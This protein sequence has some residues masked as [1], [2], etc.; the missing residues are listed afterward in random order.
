MLLLK[1]LTLSKTSIVF[2]KPDFI[3]SPVM[4]FKVTF[5][6]NF[7]LK[8]LLMDFV[9]QGIDENKKAEMHLGSPEEAKPFAKKAY[10]LNP[11]D[12]KAK[13]LK[14]IPGI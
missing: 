10:E 8:S 12:S 11:N 7:Q 3:G 1:S 2:S 9:Y 6:D 14:K 5:Y 13:V 4:G